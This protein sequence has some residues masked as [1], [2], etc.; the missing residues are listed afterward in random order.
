MGRP[1]IIVTYPHQ[2][3]EKVGKARGPQDRIIVL[4]EH[5]SFTL[6]TLLQINF[7]NWINFD[8]L[9]EGAPPYDEVEGEPDDYSAKRV[10]LVVREF[11]NIHPDNPRFNNIQK[12]ARFKRMLESVSAEDAK[13]LIA[14]KDGVLQELY[15]RVTSDLV[16]SAF[17]GL[18]N[19]KRAERPV[20]PVGK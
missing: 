7:A 15:P 18:L 2:I 16:Q 11:F 19:Q 4:Q 10:E 3:F 8:N 17:P 14:V 20:Q 9:P 12:E 13:V 1:R 5:D 6:R